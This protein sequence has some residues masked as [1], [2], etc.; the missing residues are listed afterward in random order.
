MKHKGPAARARI[1]WKQFGRELK[2]VRIGYGGLR[3]VAELLD[4]DKSTLSRAERGQP[5]EP[6]TL[7]FLAD[8]A[9]LDVRCY[10]APLYTKCR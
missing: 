2:E 8:W 10:L 1:A 9:G 4:L 7:L 6:A 5:V 3:E